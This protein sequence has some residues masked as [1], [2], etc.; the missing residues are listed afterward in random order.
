MALEREMK[1][2]QEKLPGLKADEGKYVLIQG[3]EVAGVF[4]SAEDALKAGYDRFGLEPFLVKQIQAIERVQ[5]I[6]RYV[7]PAA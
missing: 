3:E 6:S 7:K 2:Y 1:T 5:F 4:T